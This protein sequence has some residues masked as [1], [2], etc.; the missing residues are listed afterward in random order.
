MLQADFRQERLKK[1]V[2]ALKKQ[3]QQID[4][5][6]SERIEHWFDVHLFSCDS[7]KALDYVLEV[8]RNLNR[9]PQ[10]SGNAQHY[11]A[12]QLSLQI[13]ALVVAL[14]PGVIDKKQTDKRL[15]T[16]ATLASQH[17]RLAQYHEYER[18]L[19]Q[20]LLDAQ[21]LPSSPQQILHCQQRL[22]RCQQAIMQLE[23]RIR[24]QEE[25]AEVNRR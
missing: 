18:R 21:Q 7:N 24:Q 1:I 2:E 22:N 11:L 19:Q 15:T 9:L 13:E 14:R 12:Q 16:A 4:Q 23:E 3:A 17:Q 10:L 25:G 20:N 8:E 5:Q 6:L